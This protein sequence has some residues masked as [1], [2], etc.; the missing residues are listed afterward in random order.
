MAFP[1]HEQL[2]EREEALAA[3]QQLADDT[4]AERRRLAAL[5]EDLAGVAGELQVRGGLGRG[6]PNEKLF[7]RVWDSCAERV[8][9]GRLTWYLPCALLQAQRAALEEQSASLAVREARVSEQEGEVVLRLERV[10]DLKERE[11]ALQAREREVRAQLQAREEEVER[12][13]RAME[14]EVQQRLAAREAEVEQRLK[15]QEEAL[16]KQVRTTHTSMLDS[17]YPQGQV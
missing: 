9:S 12:R 17:S 15:A 2:S 6:R 13:L 4:A 5:Q 3:V 10:R 8:G 7:R 1:P 11:A 16:H 14:E